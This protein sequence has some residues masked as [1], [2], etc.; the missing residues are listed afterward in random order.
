MSVSSLKSRTIG[1]PGTSTVGNYSRTQYWYTQTTRP[2]LDPLPYETSTCVRFPQSERGSGAFPIG[3]FL[4]RIQDNPDSWWAP[5]R[6]RAY[7][8]MMDKA[9]STA[10]LAIDLAQ[11]KQAVSMIR[12][13]CYQLV[14]TARAVRRGKFGE[15]AKTLGIK[16]PRGV[17]R[18]KQ[19]ADNFLEYWFGWQPAIKDIGDAVEVLQG[20]PPPQKVSGSAKLIY[21]WQ[22]G[23]YPVYP[24]AG[25][26]A[27]RRDGLM[28]VRC[29]LTVKSVNPDLLLANQLGF[30]NPAAVLWDAIPFSFLVDWVV[31]VGQFLESMTAT[32]G[33]NISRTWTSYRQS[34]VYDH[35]QSRVDGTPIRNY[36]K[37]YHFRRDLG[38]PGVSLTVKN[39]LKGFSVA[40]AL[41]S[42]SLLIQQLK[43]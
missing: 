18:K 17:S 40:R 20:D 16:T 24:P 12:Q 32:L 30:T 1:Y 4:W 21:W 13:R 27:Y 7:A 5:L 33:M 43:L 37:S 10:G 41:V 29:G 42:I 3:G 9:R 22:L 36:G 23:P 19:F 28:R 2:Y 35:H 15:A 14:R 34:H 38:L 25:Q 11:R 39:P 8:R 26:Q 31:N 6:N